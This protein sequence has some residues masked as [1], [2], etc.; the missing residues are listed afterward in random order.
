MLA[1]ASV[2]PTGRRN[3][4]A[5]IAERRLARLDALVERRLGGACQVEVHDMIETAG[6]CAACPFTPGDDHHGD[7]DGDRPGHGHDD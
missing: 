4:L 7:D 5:R 2:A 6:Q 3:R 1:V